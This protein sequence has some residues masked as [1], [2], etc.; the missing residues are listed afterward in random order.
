MALPIGRTFV[1]NATADKG[2]PQA[3]FFLKIAP[4]SAR[5]PM[6]KSP[7]RGDLTSFFSSARLRRAVKSLFL[8]SPLLPLPHPSD[9]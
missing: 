2:A 5:F 1:N 4:S 8:P 6:Q 9:P 3:R 7:L